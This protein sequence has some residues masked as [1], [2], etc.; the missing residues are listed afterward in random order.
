MGGAHSGVSETT[1]DV[2]I[3]CAYF[4]PEAI[5]RTGQKLALTSDARTRFERG[6]DPAFLDDGLAIATFLILEYCGGT[7]SGVTRAG[8]PPVT[9][10][11]IG[12][13]PNLAETLGGLAIAADRQ[14]AI[15]ESLGFTVTGDWQV[16]APSWRRDV[17]GPADL[18]EEVIRIEG[19]DHVPPVALPARQAS[20][21]PPPRRSRSWSVAPD[22]PPP[23]AVWTKR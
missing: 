17:D 23:R 8:K 7:A 6:V 3:E 21:V 22:A 12:Y 15:L 14:K 1:T 5:A 11:T 9:A 18:V 19:I 4:A 16:T 20:R 13:D 2:I 10:K